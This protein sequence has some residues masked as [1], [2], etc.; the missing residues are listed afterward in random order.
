MTAADKLAT[1]QQVA[2]AYKMS[3]AYI[4]KMASLNQWRRVRYGG[5]VHYHWDDVGESLGK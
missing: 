5:R 3:L 1:P 4:Y 2:T